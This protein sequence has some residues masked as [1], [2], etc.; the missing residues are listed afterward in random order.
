MTIELA[1]NS[2]DV[3]LV[4]DDE[5]RAI[6]GRSWGVVHTTE[7]LARRS[8][9]AGQLVVLDDA[10]Y[11]DADNPD[12]VTALQVLD[13]RRQRH[14]A[15][16]KLP[17]A[18]LVDTVGDAV[19]DSL[20]QGKDGAPFKQ[21]LAIAAAAGDAEIPAPAPKKPTTPRRGSSER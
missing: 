8:V 18:V 9:L 1:Y 15:A 20:P 10:D 5:G 2:T 19:A 21:D 7:A 17:K 11:R 6:G 13:E 4:V 14:A 3:P 12:V 16:Q